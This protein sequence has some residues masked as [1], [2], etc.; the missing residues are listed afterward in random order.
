M[1]AAALPDVRRLIGYRAHGAARLVLEGHAA[2]EDVEGSLAAGQPETAVLMAHELIQI[3]LSIRGLAT[4]GELSWPQGQASF[5]PFAGVDPREVAEGEALAA[6]G[7]DHGDEAWLEE[8]RAHLAETESR[9]GYPEPLPYVRSGAG[10]FKA[11]GL[12]RTW[13]AHLEKL[14][15]P[16]VLPGD[17][18]LPGD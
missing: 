13:A 16:G 12:V 1:S 8:L 15:L 10:M 6:R 3:S 2:L 9:L 14:G 4:A 7:L 18:A 5:D 17:W 11:V